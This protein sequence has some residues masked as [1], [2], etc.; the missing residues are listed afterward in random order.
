M[1]VKVDDIVTLLSRG[2][3][4]RQIYFD[5]HPEVIAHSEEFTAELKRFLDE[6]GESTFF[7]GVAGRQLVYESHLLLGASIIGCRIVDL[8]QELSC[9]GIRLQCSVE[10]WEIRAWFGLVADLTEP[11]ADLATAR[12]LLDAKGIRNIEL[13]PVYDDPNWFGQESDSIPHKIANGNLSDNAIAMIPAYQSVYG[14]VEKAHTDAADDSAVDVDTTREMSGNMMKSMGDSFMDIMQL[15]DYP[16][17]DSYTVGHSVRVAMLAAFIGRYLNAPQDFILELGAAG[18]LHDIGKSRV[19]DDIIFKRGRLTAEERHI[20][21]RHPEDGAAILLAGNNASPLTISAAWGHHLRYDYKGYPA[22]PPWAIQNNA[23]ALLHICDVYEALTA[24]RPY[25]KAFSP[26]RAYEIML[27]DKG[28]FHP[29]L[30]RTFISALGLYPAGSCVLLSN[31]ER[32]VVAKAGVDIQ[33]PLVEITHER[34][35]SPVI[36]RRP[37]DLGAAQT[38]D[39]EV[40]GLLNAEANVESA[41][42]S[43]AV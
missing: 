9:G 15:V 7:L 29:V 43:S 21:E 25:K 35:G 12:A 41:E 17:F 26:R 2:I 24:V 40:N 8:L 37:L 28:A 39:I 30:L 16:D 23:T 36:S 5:N 18:L 10:P 19:P 11:V 42:L 31:G 13:S 22:S 3:S 34:D 1:A 6:Q 27:F 32:A 14:S 33:R 4:R 20:M 38:R